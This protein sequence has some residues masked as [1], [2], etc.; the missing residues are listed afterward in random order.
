MHTTILLILEIENYPLFLTRVTC[1]QEDGTTGGQNLREG[2]V[3]GNSRCS[4]DNGK[5]DT[6]NRTVWHST[7]NN[8]LSR[9]T[10]YSER[11]PCTRV[12]IVCPFT[13][14]SKLGTV[15]RHW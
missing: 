14:S 5:H 9:E 7:D 13:E 8:H 1:P 6:K 3:S 4:G 12:H 2:T 11:S 10:L 15:N